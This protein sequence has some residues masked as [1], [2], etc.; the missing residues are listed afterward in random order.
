MIV[1]EVT[2]AALVPAY[3]TLAQQIYPAGG[4]ELADWGIGRAVV[5]PGR[6]TDPHAHDEHEMFIVTGG[7]GTLTVDGERQRVVAG[8]AV[9]IPAGCTHTFANTDLEER[10]EFFNVYW[11]PAHGAIEL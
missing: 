10:L 2:D 5:D 8:Q 4:E 9:L 6:H 7:A 1:R 11:P 3:G